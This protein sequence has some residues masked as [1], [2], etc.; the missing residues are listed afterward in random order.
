MSILL[1]TTVKQKTKHLNISYMNKFLRKSSQQKQILYIKCLQKISS[2]SS[3]S[4]KCN[5]KLFNTLKL[6]AKENYFCSHLIK[7]ENNAKKR[8]QGEK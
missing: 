6:K 4:Y 5:A 7:Y 1:L 8:W 2:E 3:N